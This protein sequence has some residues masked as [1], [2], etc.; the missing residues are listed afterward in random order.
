MRTAGGSW[1]LTKI[2][3]TLWWQTCHRSSAVGGLG[4]SPPVQCVKERGSKARKTS[5]LDASCSG[6]IDMWKLLRCPICFD[7]FFR[8]LWRIIRFGFWVSD[9][10]LEVRV[11]TSD[12]LEIFAGW[13]AVELSGT[14]PRQRI[15]IIVSVP[16]RAVGWKPCRVLCVPSPA[17][18]AYEWNFVR[19]PGF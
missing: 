14:L 12:R 5:F 4:D 7:L 1:C 16:S 13:K 19:S 15:Q 9:L 18:P 3:R 8:M 2:L 10:C 11:R 17:V 6:K